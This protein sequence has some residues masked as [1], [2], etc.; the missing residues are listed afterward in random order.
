MAYKR[1]VEFAFEVEGQQFV[2]EDE[3]LSELVDVK[4]W[5]SGPKWTFHW[6]P[7]ND[8]WAVKSSQRVIGYERL[9]DAVAAFLTEN[10]L[11]TGRW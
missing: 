7:A 9:Q 2:V 3:P 4:V 1:R 8:A 6:A 11:P 10:G 5:P